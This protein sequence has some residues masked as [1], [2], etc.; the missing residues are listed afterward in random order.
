MKD[1]QDKRSFKRYKKEAELIIKAKTGAYKGRIIDY[2]DGICAVIKDASSIISGTTVNIR[3]REL[4]IEFLGEV[5]WAK[6][7]I[8]DLQVGIR[9]VD[10][11]RGSLKDFRLP[12]VLKGLQ[13]TT[14]TGTLEIHNDSIEKKIYI[15]N[16]DLIFAS[17][18]QA[19][20]SLAKALLSAGKMTLDQYKRTL[21]I[22]EQTGKN[23]S[24]ILTELGYLSTQEFIWALKNQVEMIILSSFNVT[25]ASFEF[26][27]GPL[28]ADE[29]IPLRINATNLLYHGYKKVNDLLYLKEECP[30]PDIELRLCRDPEELVQHLSLSDTDRRILSY[31]DG[32]RSIKEIS[33][34]SQASDT[35]ILK[36]IYALLNI[37]AIELTEDSVQT[38]KGMEIDVELSEKIEK[39]NNNYKTLGYYGILGINEGASEEEIREAY[40]RVAKEFHPD[41]YFSL[42]S[43]DIKEKINTI[44]SYATEAYENLTDEAKR[45]EYDRSLSVK[46]EK[47]VSK[48]EMAKE[49]FNQGRT[50][51]MMKKYSDAVTLFAQAIYFDSSTASYQY[52]HGLALSKL[53]RFKEAAKAI[54]EAIKLNP[55]KSDYVAEL[56]HVFLMLGFKAR[57]RN[58]FKRALELSPSNERAL[59]GLLKTEKNNKSIFGSSE[60]IL[61]R[62]SKKYGLKRKK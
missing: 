60:N 5:V 26:Q 23:Q 19:S 2:S 44:F 21:K 59:E 47:P 17:S 37:G 16:G 42:P 56:G 11:L 24:T 1:N 35:E 3:S 27:E 49:R 33:L 62:I 12:D 22:S 50:L 39:I 55:Q 52:Y 14:S 34:L 9:R 43:D 25:D 61:L 38:A 58:S 54:N 48:A 7:L 41:K 10:N 29:S 4:G 45:R 8:P 6:K 31:L 18:N 13:K 46:S 15:K 51:M 32:K 53:Q 57:A 36:T 40:Y 30:P 20:D 28:D